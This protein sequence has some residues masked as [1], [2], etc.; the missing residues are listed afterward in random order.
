[1]RSVMSHPSR[2]LP[3]DD[4]ISYYPGVESHATVTNRIKGNTVKVN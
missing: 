2:T 3:I 1:M 4:V